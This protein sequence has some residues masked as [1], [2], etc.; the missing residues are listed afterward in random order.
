MTPTNVLSQ[1]IALQLIV[2]IKKHLHIHNE[3]NQDQV[4]NLFILSERKNSQKN[5]E[6]EKQ[7][8]EE[9]E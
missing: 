3:C 4:K 8:R 2:R 7:R 1:P 6:E 9:L 5:Q